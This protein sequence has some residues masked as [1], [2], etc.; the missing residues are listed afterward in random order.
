MPKVIDQDPYIPFLYTTQDN[1]AISVIM[2][3]Y[4]KDQKDRCLNISYQLSDE[5]SAL[6]IS[7]EDNIPIELTTFV[8]NSD[9][10]IKDQI[11]VN[12]LNRDIAENFTITLQPRLKK[13]VTGSISLKLETN[14]ITE[15]N[16]NLSFPNEFEFLSH[17]Y[18]HSKEDR[19][20]RYNQWP[21][22]YPQEEWYLGTEKDEDKE[23][24]FTRKLFWFSIKY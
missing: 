15:T 6:Q 20:N 13:D 7:Y 1:S 24:A 18:N 17:W 23:L 2:T 11:C 4:L 12:S 22:A 14:L 9:Q 3:N 8:E 16:R 19:Y 5:N 21:L 10:W